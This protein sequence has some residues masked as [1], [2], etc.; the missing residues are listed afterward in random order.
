MKIRIILNFN[1]FY[2][3]AI[4]AK[5]R[6]QTWSNIV[7]TL[8]IVAYVQGNVRDRFGRLVGQYVISRS[9]FTPAR[10]DLQAR[11]QQITISRCSGRGE[12]PYLQFTFG[13][14]LRTHPGIVFKTTANPTDTGSILPCTVANGS[15]IS[16][17]RVKT[18]R[19]AWCDTPIEICAISYNKSRG[20]HI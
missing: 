14:P 20:D 19:S 17:N 3:A 12:R 18:M 16:L 8:R 11:D 4:L 2:Q 9:L 7:A 1:S 10:V 15:G 13:V 5:E 6:R